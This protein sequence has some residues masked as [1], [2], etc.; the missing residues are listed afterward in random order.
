MDKM[1]EGDATAL[2]APVTPIAT[3]SASAAPLQLPAPMAAP[4]K[5]KLI[6]RKSIEEIA[7]ALDF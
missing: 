3:V 1:S 5:I 7:E 4:E 2:P 6:S